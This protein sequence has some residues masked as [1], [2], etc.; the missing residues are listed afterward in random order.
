MRLGPHTLV[1][2]RSGSGKASLVWGFTLALAPAIRSGLVEVHGVDLK[3]GMELSMGEALFTRYARTGP[4]AVVVLED[5]AQA[6]QDRACR[7][8]GSTRQHEASTAEPHVLVLVD[9][10]AALTAYLGDRDL[11]RRANTALAILCSQGRA[12]GYT[13]FACLQDP[14]KETIPVR[15]LFTQMI[16]LRLADREET[17][18]VLGEGAVAAGAACHRIPAATPGIGYLIPETGGPPVRVRG[19]LISDNDIRRAAAT[20]PAP[21][22]RT[23]VASTRPDEESDTVAR[24]RQARPRRA[25]IDGGEAA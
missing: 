13:V 14:R 9:E 19:A 5:A 3:G 16:G 1:A 18:M 23:V 25:D 21:T 6:L 24:P 17:A 7:L 10:L 20:C 4:E 15:G 22:R 2:G 12:V 8:A 11:T